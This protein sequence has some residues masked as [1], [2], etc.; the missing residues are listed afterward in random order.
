MA[1]TSYSK[2]NVVKA[3]AI[4]HTAAHAPC[5]CRRRVDSVINSAFARYAAELY[6]ESPRTNGRLNLGPM[7]RVRSR[8]EERVK[9]S[10]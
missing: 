7:Y 1:D 4:K 8:G 5:Q 2:L 6:T 10:E 9:R 3:P